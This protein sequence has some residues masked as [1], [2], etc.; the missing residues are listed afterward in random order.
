[1][2]NITTSAVSALESI[3][4]DLLLFV[5]GGCHKKRHCC[6]QSAPVMQQIVQMPQPAQQAVPQAMPQAAPQPS[7]Y[8]Q[9]AAPGPAAPSG[10]YGDSIT[11]SVN[12]NGQPMA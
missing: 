10:P 5:N 1:M 2:Q 9:S 6:P 12:I 4:S 7:P 11:T 3:T 8:D